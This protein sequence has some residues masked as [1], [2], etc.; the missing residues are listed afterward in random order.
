MGG[1]MMTVGGGQ[2]VDGLGGGLQTV[3]VSECT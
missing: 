3:D 1:A 2:N